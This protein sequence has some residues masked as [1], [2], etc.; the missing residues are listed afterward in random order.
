[1]YPGSETRRFEVRTKMRLDEPRGERLLR[2]IR[3][4]RHAV[5]ADLKSIRIAD[6][7]ALSFENEPGYA[8]RDEM[9]TAARE[10]LLDSV[11]NEPTL[12]PIELPEMAGEFTYCLEKR[13]HNGMTDN[14]ARTLSEAFAIVLKKP[15]KR[16][17]IVTGSLFFVEAARR[18]ETDELESLA[19]E[20]FFNS[21]IE[22]ISH[23]SKASL[24]SGIRFESSELAKKFPAPLGKAPEAR[25]LPL[26]TLTDEALTRLSTDRLLSLSLEEMKAIQAHYLKLGREPTD[27]ELEVLA[28]TWSEHCK[29]KIFAARITYASTDE[30]DPAREIPTTVDSLFK[31]TIRN[32]TAE[33]PKPWLLSVFSDNAGI[34]AF[35]TNTA[36]C[37]KVETHNSPSALDPFGGAMTGIV[38]VNRDILGCGLGAK[39]IF[40]TNVFCT[41]SLDYTGELPERILHP[42]RVLEGVRSGVEAGGNQSGIPTVNGALVFD[43]SYLGKPLVFCGSGG[44]LPRT[45]AGR[46]C[47]EKKILPGDYIVMAGGRIG[48]DG[49]HGATFSSLEMTEAAPASAVQI[50]DPITQRRLTDFLIEAR[51]RGLY[52]AVTDNGAGG[53]SSSVGEMAGLSNGARLDVSRAPTK[54]PG[55]SPYELVISESQERMTFAVAPE[56]WTEFERLAK[57]RGVEVSHLGEFNDSGTLSIF[58]GSK[59]VADLPLSFLHDGCP[60]LELQAKWSA[61]TTGLREVKKHPSFPRAWAEVLALPNIRSKEDF[62]RQYDHEVQGASVLKPLTQIPEKSGASR[63]GPNDAAIQALNPESSIGIAVGCGILPEYSKIDAYLMAQAAVDEAIRNLLSV[64]AEFSRGDETV[65]SLID[66]FCW[67][68]PVKNEAYAADLVRACYGIR[69]ASLELKAPFISGKDSMKNDYRGKLGG[70][71]LTISVTPTLLITALGR[72]PNYE[73]R[74]R[75]ADFKSPGDRIFILGPNEMGLAGSQWAKLGFDTAGDAFRAPIVDW[76]KALPL[77]EWLG[78]EKSTRLR[79]CHDV[80]EGGL[81]TA[82][83]ESALAPGFGA[84]LELTKTELASPQFCFGEGLHTFLV[85]T[86]AEHA[87]SLSDEWMKLGIPF[88]ALGSVSA[89]PEFDTSEWS[90]SLHELEMAWRG[91]R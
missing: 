80:S 47:A 78:S 88:R 75:S 68:D 74:T 25:V 83:L 49:I 70:K 90:V 20:F 86:S 30:N 14:R 67:P 64:G 26:T 65:L 73:T 39:P 16:L 41:A 91:S 76:K 55:L 82:L 71:P 43:P 2:T 85:S 19:R 10:V 77:Y 45:I 5:A 72:V 79:S 11:L 62:I 17:Q 63:T 15:V 89:N 23:H 24:K 51:D 81:F 42:R 53:L 22:Q 12:S 69:K 3:T 87:A 54:Y 7:Y 28:Q 36:V 34:V 27:V 9:E 56:S 59:A 58:V 44:I 61:R 35:D 46:D 6:W 37:I 57:R 40:N 48:K 18:L 13:L 33:L 50:G 38:G 84:K 21:E 32:T 66:N 29:H 8:T 60:K 31:T 4:A 1:M 52:R